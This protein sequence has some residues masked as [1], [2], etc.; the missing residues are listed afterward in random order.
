[1]SVLASSVMGRL[2]GVVMSCS[3]TWMPPVMLQCLLLQC[4]LGRFRSTSHRYS[5]AYQHATELAGA[6]S[7]TS[8]GS[9][10]IPPGLMRSSDV[11]KKCYRAPFPAVCDRSKG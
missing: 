9:K 6:Q 7:P 3:S 11:G 1:M 5:R 8:P 4:L 2:V 10:G